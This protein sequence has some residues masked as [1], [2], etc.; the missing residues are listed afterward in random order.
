LLWLVAAAHTHMMAQV[1]LVLVDTK[2]VPSPD[3]QVLLIL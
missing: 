2:Q 1:V 3:Q